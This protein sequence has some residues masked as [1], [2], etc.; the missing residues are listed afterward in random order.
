MMFAW[1]LG[2]I[3]YKILYKILNVFL[4]LNVEQFVIK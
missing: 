1:N 2:I 3:K 4:S